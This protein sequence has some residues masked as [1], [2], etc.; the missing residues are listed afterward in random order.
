[1]IREQTALAQELETTVTI[2]FQDCDPFQHLNNARYID[3]FLNARED[4]LAQFYNFR[5]FEVAQ[6]TNH[7]WVVTRNQIAYLAPAMMQE[8]VVIR[9][10]LIQMTDSALA[11]EG[12]MF[13]KAGR[14]LKAVI[15]VEFTF[16]S[17]ATGRTAKHPDE[18]MD[19]FRSAFVDGIYG[20]DGFNQ[21][22]ETLKSQ[23]RKPEVRGET[24]SNRAAH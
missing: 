17:L 1:M 4:Q 3:Y 13:D 20:A 11:F 5:I 16:V 2:R 9:T 8:Q 10:K 15:W 22:V 23:F 19:S 18:F 6:Q 24:E 12:L 7:G 14:R 21:R